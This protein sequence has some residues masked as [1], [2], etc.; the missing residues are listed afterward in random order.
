MTRK[1]FKLFAENISKIAD[2]AERRKQAENTAQ[3][4][5]K[6]NPRFDFVRFYAA[7]NAEIRPLYPV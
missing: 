3:I 5:A 6:S 4:C 7:C 1:H 2:K